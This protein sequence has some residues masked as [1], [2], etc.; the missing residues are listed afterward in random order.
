MSPI[1]LQTKPPPPTRYLV[2]TEAL[3]IRVRCTVHG[4]ILWRHRGDCLANRLRSGEGHRLV[5]ISRLRP[6]AGSRVVVLAAID[7]R[8]NRP[9]HRTMARR[10]DHSLLDR[11]GLTECYRGRGN[12]F[13]EILID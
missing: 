13:L 6:A 7:L 8:H 11:A 5:H 3:K 9:S 2:V 4:R 12:G 10:P 1:L